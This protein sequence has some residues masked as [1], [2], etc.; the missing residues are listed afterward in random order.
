VA[1]RQRVSLSAQTAILGALAEQ[2]FAALRRSYHI[3]Y[4]RARR[5]LL[6]LPVPWLVLKTLW[7]AADRIRSHRLQPFLPEPV[8]ILEDQ[9]SWWWSLG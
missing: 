2:S 1:P 9:G 4:S 6:R 8:G 5:L 7:E 3:S